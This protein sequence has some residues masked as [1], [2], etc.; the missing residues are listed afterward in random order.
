MRIPRTGGRRALSRT[1]RAFH[2]SVVIPLI[3][4]VAST[5]VG[6]ARAQ[7]KS[8]GK[9]TLGLSVA[10]TF[11]FLPAHAADDLGTWK[12]RGLD[13]TIVVFPGDARL[14]QALSLIHI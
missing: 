2:T 9:V 1:T 5:G 11:E 7:P 8:L 6:P 4:L 3:A 14:H 10:K 13:V 12:K